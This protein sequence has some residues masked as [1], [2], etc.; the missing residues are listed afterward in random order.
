M[1]S[2][3]LIKAIKKWRNVKVPRCSL[4]CFYL[5]LL[6]VG[7]ISFPIISLADETYLVSPTQL[8]QE[9]MRQ[10]PLDINLIQQA[11][12]QKISELN[13]L[14]DSDI[15][16]IAQSPPQVDLSFY[17]VVSEA[18]RPGPVISQSINVALPHPIFLIGDDQASKEW[19]EKYA[20]QLQK[21]Q[22]E[23]FVVNVQNAGEMEALRQ[24]V[25]DLPLHPLPGDA[26]A[27]WLKLE[28]YPALIS[29]HRIEQ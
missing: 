14:S 15:K 16:A 7:F 4:L 20:D 13:Q 27:T 28:H 3:K 26:L 1:K 2:I 29:N 24:E 22:A 10:N 19:L 11:T 6:V 9:Y 17:P 25:P 18:L 5:S 12:M 21:I 8:I 23:G